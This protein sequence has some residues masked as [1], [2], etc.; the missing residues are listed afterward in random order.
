M[1]DGATSAAPLSKMMSPPGGTASYT[2]LLA[3]PG[4]EAMD[5]LDARGRTQ[6]RPASESR[7]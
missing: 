7:L 6:D 4:M 2:L 1:F 5:V 3:N